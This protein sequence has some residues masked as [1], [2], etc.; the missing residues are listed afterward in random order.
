MAKREAEFINGL[1]KF[2]KRANNKVNIDKM[3]L[4]GS[5]ARGKYKK[6]SDFDLLVVSSRFMRKKWE[7]REL[8]LYPHW[9][10]NEL[11]Q[12]FDFLC[13]TPK[14]FEKMKNKIC[15]VRTAVKEGIEI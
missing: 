13:Y 5:R 10:F 2:K 9:D 7:E 1:R 3:L 6:H 14:E 12:G 11:E 8:M 15:I 4:F